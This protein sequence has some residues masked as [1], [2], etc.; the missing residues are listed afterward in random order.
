MR[1]AI[2]KRDAKVSRKES[3]HCERTKLLDAFDVLLEI[4]VVDVGHEDF[5]AVEDR[6]TGE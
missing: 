4:A 6:V 5:P 3:V 2:A 1:L